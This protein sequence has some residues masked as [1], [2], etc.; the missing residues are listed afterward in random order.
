MTVARLTIIEGNEN[1]VTLNVIGK[2][3][4]IVASD[5][6]PQTAQ[7]YSRAFASTTSDVAAFSRDI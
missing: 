4:A 6:P 7:S 1:A 5:Q 2:Q 3:Q